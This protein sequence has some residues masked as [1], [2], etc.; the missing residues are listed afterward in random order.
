M[1]STIYILSGLGVD[2]RVFNLIDFGENKVSYIDWIQPNFNESIE[3]YAKR[4]STEII[5]ENPILI[6]LSFG[7]IIA[8]ELAKII[9]TKHIIYIS[10]V[11]NFDELPY[12]YRLIGKTGLH[13]IIPTAFLKSSNLFTYW[14]FGVST[15]REKRLLKRILDDTD[16]IFLKWAINSIV[17]W[18]NN[19]NPNS[20][21]CIHGAKDRIIP[22]R[23]IVVNRRIE[24][25]GH[26]AVVT[27]H[28]EI[29][30]FLN[31]EFTRLI[32]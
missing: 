28:K 31:T 3:S 1:S 9:K 22:I 27:N 32:S 16:S 19:I 4:I 30:D 24:S 13:R 10:S 11:K 23:N 8:T 17:K 15:D 7:G 29:S 20:Y 12:Y 2:K 18:N 14:L 21:S 25:A 6:G 26:F 5:D